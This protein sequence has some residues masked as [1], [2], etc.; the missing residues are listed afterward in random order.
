MS[1]C[2][3]CP[4]G[5]YGDTEGLTTKECSGKCSDLNTLKTKYYGTEVGLASRSDC[6]VCPG[7]YLDVQAQCDNKQSFLDMYAD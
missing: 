6:K 1:D 5:T 2:R 4:R 7:G 3:P